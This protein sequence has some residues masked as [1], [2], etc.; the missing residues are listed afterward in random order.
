M[1]HSPHYSW[2]RKTQQAID[3]SENQAASGAHEKSTNLLLESKRWWALRKDLV[4]QIPTVHQLEIPRPGSTFTAVILSGSRAAE[5]LNL[6]EEFAV[7]VGAFA[8]IFRSG[9]SPRAKRKED[10]TPTS[11]APQ[12]NEIPAVNCVAP[13][14]AVPCTCELEDATQALMELK[15]AEHDAAQKLDVELVKMQLLLQTEEKRP[16]PPTEHHEKQAGF[17]QTTP[18]LDLN[19]CIFFSFV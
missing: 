6:D 9:R 3:N 1:L 19:R 15:V 5:R 2:N 14:C 8:T 17:Q 10:E 16:P 7:K 13:N 4:C 18:K 11:N 12:G